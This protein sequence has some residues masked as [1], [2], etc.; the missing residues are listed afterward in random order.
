MAKKTAVPKTKVV[1]CADCRN[2]VDVPFNS[3]PYK[4]ISGD[5]CPR[6]IS[7]KAAYPELY[8]WMLDI[9]AKAKSDLDDEISDRVVSSS[10]PAYRYY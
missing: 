9:V 4:V 6:C 1:N 5:D 7:I 8:Q 2:T 10:E 3:S